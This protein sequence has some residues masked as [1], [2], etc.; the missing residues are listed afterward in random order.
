MIKRLL[1][2]AALMFAAST[3]AASAAPPS[4]ELP[5][6]CVIGQTC[7]VQNYMDADPGPAFKDYRCG[8]RTYPDH[9][10]VDFRIRDLAAMR[11]G[12]PVLASAAGTVTR[13]RDGVADALPNQPVSADNPQACGNGVVISHADG[14]ESQYCHMRRGSVRVKTGQVVKAG[15]PLG[16]VGQSGSAAFPHVHVTVR[17]GTTTIDPFAYGPAPAP[18]GGGIGLWSPGA[19]AALRY[20]PR[21]VLVSGFTSKEADVS[22]QIA[23]GAPSAV[24]RSSP[25]I[26]PYVFVL[27]LQNGDRQEMTLTAPDGRAVAGIKDIAVRGD[28]AQLSMFI[29]ARLRGVA[30][31]AGEYKAAYR[32]L[33]DGKPVLERRFSLKL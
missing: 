13:L 27:G 20:K 32:V 7:E 25:V 33:R 15:D 2:L 29:G 9:G 21:A 22:G 3:G 30:W 17:Q 8:G 11:A 4:L 31:P 19:A 16:L 6:A 24:T 1:G 18:C 5:I 26:I 10:G 14:W 28:K 23:Q 12:V